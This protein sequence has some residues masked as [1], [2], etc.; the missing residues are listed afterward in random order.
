VK[1]YN[2]KMVTE[3]AVWATHDRYGTVLRL[4]KQKLGSR[5]MLLV[6][7]FLLQFQSL[8][9]GPNMA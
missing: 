5:E 3:R 8:T 2:I 7:T 1:G 4:S 6:V 9:V